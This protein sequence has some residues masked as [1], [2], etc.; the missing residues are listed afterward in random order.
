MCTGEYTYVPWET[1]LRV[2]DVGD[3]CKFNG[4]QKY[5]RMLSTKYGKI[6][7]DKHT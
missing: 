7:E 2:E 4:E 6:N 1:V 5:V 3:T